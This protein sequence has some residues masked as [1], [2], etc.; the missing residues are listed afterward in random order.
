MGGA[1][2]AQICT[3]KLAILQ[4]LLKMTSEIKRVTCQ[5]ILSPRQ[6][7]KRSMLS[8]MKEIGNIYGRQRAI[9]CAWAAHHP[10]FSWKLV[11]EVLCH[12]RNSFTLLPRLSAS[13]SA[14]V[15]SF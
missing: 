3:L 10:L 14:L 13:Q 8:K 7:E 1:L 9:G 4:T 6:R 11:L 5:P 15:R 12:T 2:T